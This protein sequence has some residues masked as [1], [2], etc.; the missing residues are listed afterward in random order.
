MGKPLG[1]K[2]QLFFG[3]TLLGLSALGQAQD[4]PNRPIKLLIPYPPGGVPD[5]VARSVAPAIQQELGQPFVLENRPGAGGLTA[6][7][8]FLRAPAD[9]HTLLSGDSGIWAVLP[10]LRPGN[11]DPE[12]SFVPVAG[13]STNSLYLTVSGE[14][15][16]KSVQELVATLKSKPGGYQ[17][18]STGNGSLHHLFMESF[19]AA[20][21]VDMQHIP[22]KGSAQMIQAVLA[23]DVLVTVVGPAATVGMVKAGKLRWLATTTRERS[24]LTP[25][26]PS[27]TDIGMPDLHF[28][29]DVAYFAPAGTPRAA[30]TRI[31][32]TIAKALQQPDVIQ[33]LNASFLDPLYRNP[34][35]MAEV[36]RS[37]LV[38]FTRAIK[39]SGAKVD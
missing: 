22:Y 13:V 6:M 26:I 5:T 7:Q 37:D 8:E 17:Y 23:G 28:S 12:K 4:F 10:V 1:T 38:R 24:R 36:V 21:G 18:A 2:F 31:S 16:V 19:R 9:G 33:R 11:F 14:L 35:Q 32:A 25:E 34:E 15:P 39:V 29:G 20:A 30:V 27:T 3:V